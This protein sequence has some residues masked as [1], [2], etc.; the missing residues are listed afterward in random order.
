[1]CG[2][3]AEVASISNGSDWTLQSANVNPPTLTTCYKLSSTNQAATEII[4]CPIVTEPTVTLLLYTPFP[5]IIG[6]EVTFAA[7][8]E[9]FSGDPTIVYSVNIPC[10]QLAFIHF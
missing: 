3:G 7:A 2:I 6:D 1:M 9:N 8:T 5:I 10:Y 4:D